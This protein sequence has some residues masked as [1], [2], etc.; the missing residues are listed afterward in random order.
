MLRFV[1]LIY[2]MKQSKGRVI[3]M[4]NY[5]FNREENAPKEVFIRI[6]SFINLED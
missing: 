2:I 3:C 4:E 6:N 5:G 1:L